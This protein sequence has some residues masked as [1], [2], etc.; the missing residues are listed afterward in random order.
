MP[1]SSAP[2][3]A[4]GPA[5]TWAPAQARRALPPR[6]RGPTHAQPR[7]R[8]RLARLLPQSLARR[9]LRPGQARRHDAASAS[10]RLRRGL[11]PPPPGL[12]Q[13]TGPSCRSP[14]APRCSSWFPPA[15][16]QGGERAGEPGAPRSPVTRPSCAGRVSVG[17]RPVTR[18][19]SWSQ[20]G[21]THR[22]HL[23]HP[24]PTP[25]RCAR[26]QVARMR[27]STSTR[28]RL[29]TRRARA[30][31][32]CVAQ[33]LSLDDRWLVDLGHA[34]PPCQQQGGR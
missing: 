1:A 32:Q 4:A 7:P 27:T 2:W 13:R 33:R 26:R 8:L 17:Q 20:P 21:R 12:G 15:G 18:R 5:P 34:E 29:P 10:E 31:D 30:T 24:H 23:A 28:G 6:P 19:E 3:C 16:Q 9:P 11:P 22:R 25:R 14:F